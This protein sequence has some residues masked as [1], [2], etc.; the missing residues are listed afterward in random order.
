MKLSRLFR[1][2]VA[3]LAATVILS[4]SVFAFAAQID[5]ISNTNGINAGQFKT[6]PP[7]GY[8]I[9][10]VNFAPANGDNSADPVASAT[11]TLTQGTLASEIGTNPQNTRVQARLITTETT[12]TACT[13]DGENINLWKCST[14]AR[15][16]QVDTLNV[17]ASSINTLP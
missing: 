9:N 5:G 1:S 15:M 7:M 12:Y 17:I 3:V 6:I 4:G 10:A 8:A 13:F 16:S 2:P 11:F 14:D